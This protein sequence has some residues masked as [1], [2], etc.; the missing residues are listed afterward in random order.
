M[1]IT[2]DM[3]DKLNGQIKLE[4]SAAYQYLSMA[5]TFDCMGLKILAQ[6]FQQQYTEEREHA[7]K[8]LG[9]VQEVGGAVK[10]EAVPKP[11]GDFSTVQ[12]IVETALESELAVTRA[13]GE[14]MEAAISEKD[15]ATQS[16][17]KWFVDEQVEE[18]SS[19]T[20]LLT[21]VKLAGDNVLQ[22][23]SRIRHQMMSDA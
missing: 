22:V 20:D 18:V 23:E 14:L 17:L 7:L 16:F 11:R 12:A 6:L 8:I 2:Q 9:Y 5:C 21:L 3:C 1:M 19:M 15:H 4:F 10:L 13:V